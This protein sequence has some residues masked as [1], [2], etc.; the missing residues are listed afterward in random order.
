MDFAEYTQRWCHICRNLQQTIFLGQ[1]NSKLR[2]AS[3]RALVD[4]AAAGC[5][6]CRIFR[7]QLANRPR[8]FDYPSYRSMLSNDNLPPVL[9]HINGP[10]LTLQVGSG[11]RPN[12]RVGLQGDNRWEG[13]TGWEALPVGSYR[14]R[15]MSPS[16]FSLRLPN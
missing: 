1:E 2:F 3:V 9:V 10:M 4:S 16:C 7:Q 13:G 11:R 6:V 14:Q 5:P 8:S 12:L 15:M